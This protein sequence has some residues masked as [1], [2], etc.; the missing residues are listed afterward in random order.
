VGPFTLPVVR[1]SGPGALFKGAHAGL[2]SGAAAPEAV[3]IRLRRAGVKLSW[4]APEII[5][6]TAAFLDFCR[7]RGESSVEVARSDPSLLPEMQLGAFFQAYW[8]RRVVRL[9][10]CRLGMVL[11]SLWGPAGFVGL[12]ADAAFWSGVRSVATGAEWERFARNPYVAGP[13]RAA[14]PS[15]TGWRRRSGAPSMWA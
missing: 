13:E 12:A 4:G 3:A 5:P 6:D 2:P 11:P 8:R 9:A 15:V 7:A 10:A 14:T 1:L